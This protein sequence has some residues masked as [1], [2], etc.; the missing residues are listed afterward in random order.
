MNRATLVLLAAVPSIGL[1][2]DARE[3]APMQWHNPPAK[4]SADK[5]AIT[6]DVMP[7]TDYWRTTHYGYNR[8]SGHFY[9]R[10]M[11]GDFVARVKV[12]GSYRELYDQAGLMIRID[13]T[14]WI[15]AGIEFVNNSQ[16]VST[17]VTRGFSDWSV[18]PLAHAPSA[19]WLELVRK[20][21]YVEVSYSLDGRAFVV[22]REAYFPPGTKV[23][24]G[25]MAAAPEG[26]G[27]PVTFEDFTVTGERP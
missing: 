9:Y 12:K 5:N 14:G 24:I 27:F 15:K 21:D 13:E 17:V 11:G 25:V 23:Q 26:K 4:W 8:D 7:K 6:L 20:S 19:I 18:V 1:R 10:E 2:A 3:V 16:N 22:V